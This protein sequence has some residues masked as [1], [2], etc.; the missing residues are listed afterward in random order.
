[1]TATSNNNKNTINMQT[2]VLFTIPL[3][4]KSEDV[5]SIFRPQHLIILFALLINDN[6]TEPKKITPTT[7]QKK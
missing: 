5:L 4:V 6:F 3:D 7:D 2:K 1:M